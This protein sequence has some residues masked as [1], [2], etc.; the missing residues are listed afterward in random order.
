VAPEPETTAAPSTGQVPAITPPDAIATE[1]DHNP[2]TPTHE[3]TEPADPPAA[4]EAALKAFL[5]AT[6][7]D[8][9]ARH[10]LQSDAT[11]D[12]PPHNSG[13]P[14]E[15]QSVTADPAGITGAD[16]SRQLVFTVIT[17]THPNG[18]PATVHETPDGWKVDSRCFVEARDDLFLKFVSGPPG[19]SGRFHLSVSTPPAER[20]ART[21]NEHFSSF[22]LDAPLPGRQRIAY[23][24]KSAD[25][26][27]TLRQAT[28]EGAALQGVLEITKRTTPDEREYLEITAIS[29][30]P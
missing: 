7:D 25:F 20:A 22:L 11:A 21:E 6:N 12:N 3:S 19:T 15:Y 4:A 30:N 16:G 13:G 28:A 2:V 1:P 10:A 24:R 27:Q 18:F 8:E 26:H 14:T 9:R 17:A 29:P 23:V 5:E